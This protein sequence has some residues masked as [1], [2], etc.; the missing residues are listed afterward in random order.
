MIEPFL[1]QWCRSYAR[2]LRVAGYFDNLNGIPVGVPT[3]CKQKIFAPD[4]VVRCASTS[5]RVCIIIQSGF[6]CTAYWRTWQ[7]S[8]C[9]LSSQRLQIWLHRWSA[10]LMCRVMDSCQARAYGFCCACIRPHQRDKEL[11]LVVLAALC[12]LFNRTVPVTRRECTSAKRHNKSDVLP[13]A[14][15]AHAEKPSDHRF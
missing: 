14:W 4:P 7:Q 3:L 6:F 8:R 9:C 11:H 2:Q 12:A 15:F 5:F 13:M 1:S 10:S